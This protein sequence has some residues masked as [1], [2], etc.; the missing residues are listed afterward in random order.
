MIPGFFAAAYGYFSR[1]RLLLLGGTVALLLLTLAGFGRI[2][3][4]EN[5]E[6]MLPDRGSQVAGD[7][8]LLQQ[9][10][11]AR[12][13]V[14]TLRSETEGNAEALIAA[15]D[16]LAAA[17]DPK[18]FPLVVTG[19]GNQ[20]QTG[21][22]P[23]LLEAL[24]SLLSEAELG[25][26]ANDLQGEGVALRLQE[27]YRHLLAPE[28]WAMKGLIRRDPLSL[29]TLA[30]EKL[31]FLNMIPQ[32]RLV[33]EHF[34]TADGKNALLVAETTIPITDS[35]G[36]RALRDGFEAAAAKTVPPGITAGMLSGHL[37]TLA[38]AEAI[39]GDL[40][41]I[42]GCSTLAMAALFFCFLRSFRAVFVFLVP[43]AVLC[44]ATVAVALFYPSVSAVTIGFGGVLLGICVDFGLHVYFALRQGG[45]KPGV[46]LGEVARP[47]LFGGLTTI[48][49]FSVL[50]FSD[51]PGQRQLAV[52]SIAGLSAALLLSLL[53]LPHLIS[54]GP[55]GSNAVQP[56]RRAGPGGSDRRR[57]LI[58]G[59]WG[60]LMA[61][62]LWQ[63]LQLQFNGDLRRM[64]LTPP[65][66]QAAEQDLRRTWGDF[67][68]QAMLW[69]EGE[70]LQQALQINGRLFDRLSQ[71]EGGFQ[72]VSIAPLLPAQEVQQANRTRWR[73]FW[74][75][76]EGRGVLKRLEME[77]RALGFSDGAFEP[78]TQALA[79]EAQNLT[80]EDFEKAGLKTLVDSLVSRDEGRVRVLTL[81]PDSPELAGWI[82]SESDLPVRLVS[83]GH[84]R[85]QISEAIGRDFIRFIL[86]ASVV[87]LVLLSLLF[88]H[89]GKVLAAATPVVTGLLVMFGITGALG[90]EFNLF[91]IVASV[92]VIGLGVDYG[93]FMVCKVT[94][95]LDRATGQAVLVSGLTTLAGFGALVLARHPA[96][97]SIG[98]TVLL[99]IGAAI[100]AALLVVPAFFP[101]N[102]R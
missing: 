17:L 82:K 61:L 13:L 10:P 89:P 100:P 86:S 67:R 51:L 71:Q 56:L 49:A 87:V 83:Q 18:L 42:I 54:T 68:G 20:L 25:A 72:P 69:A 96:L 32:A 31:R 27:S 64:S 81:V 44:F 7:F 88:R 41:R 57:Y 85:Q 65:E 66:L 8:R 37:Y 91:N 35:A 77:A 94:E 84:F 58:I 19:P 74:Q 26:L 60:L 1:R 101:G 62:C 2:R 92:L 46:V 73:A 14:I 43:V 38:N 79:S 63:A 28:G 29:H 12:K 40:W 59:G 75:G 22:I 5:I 45:D 48:A 98:V 36:A 3:M 78:F 47:V 11:F 76:E 4:E 34:V 80:L 70:D 23:L 90:W 93:I 6:A 52:F 102:R 39:Q 99:G 16:E 95:G 9:A 15:V 50:L 97:H 24:P 53:V 55:M 30:L 33:A 21:L